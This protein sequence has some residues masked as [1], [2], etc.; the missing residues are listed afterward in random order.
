[1]GLIA[2]KPVFG[3]SAKAS[4]K[5][6]SSATETSKKIETSSAASL[7]MILSKNR[8]RARSRW[9]AIANP[10]VKVFDPPA[11]TS[12]TPGHDSGNRM[13]I[14]LNMFSIFYM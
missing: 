11:P 10:P 7:D 4:F 1:M 5:P 6:V 3:V 12:P 8:T 9:G 14:L 2:R 13:K